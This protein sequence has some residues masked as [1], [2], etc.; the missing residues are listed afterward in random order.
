MFEFLNRLSLPRCKI[1]NDAKVLLG[2]LGL[3]MLSLAS[4]EAPLLT[5]PSVSFTEEAYVNR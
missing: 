5:G 4:T 1:C 2:A 3:F